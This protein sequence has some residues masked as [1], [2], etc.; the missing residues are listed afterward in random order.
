MKASE[1]G[2]FDKFI[3]ALKAPY[4]WIMRLDLLKGMAELKW[5]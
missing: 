2:F 5:A 3:E 1:F 4:N